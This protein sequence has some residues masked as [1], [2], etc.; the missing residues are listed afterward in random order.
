MVES[1]DNILDGCIDRLNRGESLEACLGDYPE[2]REEL[3][4]LLSA[5]LETKAA[6]SFT[7]SGTTKRAAKQRFTAAL[8]KS[9]E[10]P[11]KREP[12]SSWVF[13]W[14]KVWATAAA[15]I[16]I[17][18][19]GYFGLRPALL[20]PV[21]VA[22]PSLEGN[23]AFLISDEVNA[24]ADFEN[25]S[26]SVSKI[27]LHLSGEEEKW[28][29]LEPEVQV[30]DLTDLQGSRA[31]QVWRGN[32]PE[33]EYTKVF[34]QVSHVSGIL[35]DTGE[36]IEI[37]L[38]SG[39]LQISKPFVVSSDDITNFVYDITVVKAGKSGQY[40][41]KPQIGQSGADQDFVKVEPKGNQ[42]KNSNTKEPKKAKKSSGANQ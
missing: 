29:E 20:P 23:F 30:V 38:P 18:L 2:H 3:K 7:P 32:V 37:K 15:V 31:Q 13:G 17:G 8:V 19:L 12:S 6:Y 26:V 34:I 1:L 10:R 21:M 28:I 16:V 5:M 39:K 41:L 36:E 27:S 25:L 35:K 33:G 40:V 14:A 9:R 24:I 42:D 22:Q 4:P 11:G